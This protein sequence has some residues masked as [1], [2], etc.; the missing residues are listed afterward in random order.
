MR[1]LSAPFLLCTTC[2]CIM[3]VAAHAQITLPTPVIPASRAAPDPKAPAPLYGPVDWKKI[4]SSLNDDTKNMMDRYVYINEDATDLNVSLARPILAN[5]EIIEW[6]KVHLG[7]I[8]TL[9]GTAYDRKLISN[10]LLFT[11]SGYADYVV[12]LRD[13]NMGK[14]LKDNS[15][16]MTGFVEGD[17]EVTSQGTRNIP[18]KIP[19]EAA[20]PVYVWQMNADI[21][22]SYLDYKNEAPVELF[23]DRDKRK[24]N[25]RF[26][27][28][29]KM[30]LIRIPIKETGDNRVA[31]NRISFMSKPADPAPA[32][33][34]P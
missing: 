26:P 13:A 7:Q 25:N 10:Q 34:T 21:V 15:F 16:K 24:I 12:Y 33:K 19:G 22:L 11:P 29:V 5:S 23:P 14:F 8:M 32:A 2:L 3:A 30:E 27:L 4:G 1:F 28:K 31:I 6:V 20:K 18:S 17:P 9:D